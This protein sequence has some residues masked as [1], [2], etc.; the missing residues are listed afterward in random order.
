MD[1]TQPDAEPATYTAALDELYAVRRRDDASNPRPG[2]RRSL[3]DEALRTATLAKHAHEAVFGPASARAEEAS[4]EH[5]NAVHLLGV[6]RLAHAGGIRIVE[7]PALAGREQATAV[8][9]AELTEAARVEADAMG[10]RIRLESDCAPWLDGIRSGLA[11]AA[12]RVAGACAA[13]EPALLA[14]ADAEDAYAQLLDDAA[15]RLIA[16]GF[17]EAWDF[18]GV[19]HPTSPGGPGRPMQLA[20]VPWE[21]ISPVSA[22]S[23]VADVRALAEAVAPVIE[24]EDAQRLPGA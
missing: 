23:L 1:T 19:Q 11:A 9:A 4:A 13:A 22:P 6:A 8:R 17:D 20:G 18:G 16:A 5:R 14:L 21:G 24:R 3:H 12:R 15:E 10:A 7:L 2:G